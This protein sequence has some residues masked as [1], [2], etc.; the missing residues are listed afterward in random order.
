MFIEKLIE[1]IEV[2][3]CVEVLKFIGKKVFLNE[4]A[5][6]FYRALW[7]TAQITFTMLIF[8]GILSIAFKGKLPNSTKF[9]IALFVMLGIALL[10]YCMTKNYKKVS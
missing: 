9:G 1:N 8:W 3:I 7:F 4:K 6:T 10:G 2:K 5:K